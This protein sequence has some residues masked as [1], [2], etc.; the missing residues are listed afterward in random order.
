MILL[1]LVF[2]EL[3]IIYEV[4]CDELVEIVIWFEFGGIFLVEIM[5]LWECGEKLVDIC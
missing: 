2:E 4:V 3:E 1:N 5:I